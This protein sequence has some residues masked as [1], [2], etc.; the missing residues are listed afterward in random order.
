LDSILGKFG[1]INHVRSVPPINE[2][3]A[4]WRQIDCCLTNLIYITVS[5]GVFDLIYKPD[6]SAFTIWI[7]IEGLFCDNEMQRAV[8]LEAEFRSV[9]QGDLSISDYCN[10]PKKPANN[11]RDVGRPV[12]DPSQV[13]NLL[14]SLNKKFR[15]VKPVLTAKTHTFMSVRSYMLLEELQLHQDDKSEASQVLLDSHGGATDSGRSACHGSS[16]STSGQPANAGHNAS[17]SGDTN[18]SCN[19]RPHNKHR[20]HGRGGDGA[21]PTPAAAVNALL[22][23]GWAPRIPGLVL[24]RPGACPSARLALASWIPGCRSRPSRPCWPNIQASPL[25][26]L[27]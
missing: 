2:R 26:A 27:L 3:D 24:F 7:D 11:L 22:L 10:K 18:G 17:S 6:A 14:C 16:P 23:S 21:D 4:G 1:L 5:K 25:R 13:L 20:G 19:F 15:H 8:L 12:S 9:V